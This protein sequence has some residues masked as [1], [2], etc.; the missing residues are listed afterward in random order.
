MNL[1]PEEKLLLFK[2]FNKVKDQL[3]VSTSENRLKRH[4]NS[5]VLIIDGSN[6]FI[7]C[8]SA[9]PSMNANGDHN[10]GI[11]GFFRS[12]GYAIKMLHPTRC[13]I[14]FDGIGGSFRR[15]KIYPEYKAHRRNKIRL[16]RIYEDQTELDD[17]QKNGARQ[18]VRLFHYLK[19]FPLNVLCL[20]HVEAD[21]AIAY[22]ALDEFK[23]SNVTIMS[24]DKDFLQLVRPNVRVWSPTKKILYG[25]GDVVREYNIHPK[26]FILFRILD[27]DD[28]DNIPGIKGAGLKTILKCFPFLSED[29]E[30]N[31][32]D[33][34]SY[35][36]NTNLK[37]KLYSQIIEEEEKLK[38]N[39]QLM[40]LKDTLL[41]TVAQLKLK[42]ILESTRIPKMNRMAIVKMI[43]EDCM[44]NNFPDHQSWL[45]EVFSPLDTI[46]NTI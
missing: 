14:T 5:D 27:G 12:I 17:E 16:H 19:H 45:T 4:I 35:S 10:G 9:I 21:D 29:K 37:Y 44:I 43:M 13:I 11:V 25:Q 32:E 24:S 8:W 30:F 46:R 33:I 20:D 28:S 38:L 40:Q 23:D 31:V 2:Q 34:I 18:L 36:K 1:T 15:R 26:N 42:D 22:C 7:R 41:T 39:Y 3:N 6:T